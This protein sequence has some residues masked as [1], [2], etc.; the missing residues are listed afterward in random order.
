MKTW[1]IFLRGINVGGHKK[2]KMADL[3]ELLVSLGFE[4]V[5]TYI[6]SGNVVLKTSEPDPGT[7]I[8]K[9]I[10]D[11]LG[12]EVPVFAKAPSEIEA[13]LAQCP[14][15][16][17]KKL[18][19]YFS[20]LHAVPTSE[21]MEAASAISYPDEEFHITDSCIYFYCATG[22]GK[23]KLSNNWFEKKLGVSA[24]AR[25]YR[26]LTKMLELARV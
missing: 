17:E 18:K 1:I 11:T 14:F 16:E 25:N 26:T 23:A 13:V 20:L 15:S 6:Q 8:E 3:R 24:T 5:Q 19:S 21:N 4:A 7:I 2:I 12:W 10:K 9:G 22:Y